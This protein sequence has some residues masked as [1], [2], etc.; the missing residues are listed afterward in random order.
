MICFMPVRNIYFVRLRGRKL[1]GFCRDRRPFVPMLPKES[2]KGKRLKR[3]RGMKRQREP[4]VP[5]E[6][7]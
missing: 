1:S 2:R 4:V 3:W 6:L 7:R 5:P